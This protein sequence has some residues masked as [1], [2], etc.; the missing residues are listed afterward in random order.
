MIRF[1]GWSFDAARRL[2]TIGEGASVHLTPKAFDLLAILIVEAPRVVPRDELH[3]RLWPDSFVS[4]AT[5]SGLVKE[6][7]SAFRNVPG[8]GDVVRT[9][10]GIGFALAIP[11]PGTPRTDLDRLPWVITPAGRLRLAMG[12]N[13]IG[14]DPGVDIRLTGTDVSRRHARIVVSLGEAWLQDLESKN[15]TR[16]NGAACQSPVILRDGDT[17]EVGR[18]T[19]LFRAADATPSTDTVMTAQG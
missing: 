17:I 7:R 1:D 16:V 14:R 11:V 12:E 9:C 10:H 15:G 13:V 18:L 3:T 4:E 2:V 5:L 6:V 8:G 19:L